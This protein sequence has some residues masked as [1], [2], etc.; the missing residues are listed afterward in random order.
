VA[1]EERPRH[2]IIES[3][4][5]ALAGLL[6]APQGPANG[7]VLVCHG[8]G[9]RKENHADFA[10]YA[11]GRGLAALIF[12]FRGHGES[13]GAGDDAMHHDVVAC[14]RRL[15]AESSAP[16][17][18]ARGS[19]MGGYLALHAAA[20]R[21]GL[22]SSVVAICPASED[23][24]LDGLDKLDDMVARGDREAEIYGR[25]DSGLM[26]TFYRRNDLLRRLRGMR[27]VLL[28]HCRD[29]D[30]VPVAHSERLLHALAEP[31]R[32][33]ALP[34]GGH[35]GAQHDP[36]VHRASLDWIVGA[37]RRRGE[38]AKGETRN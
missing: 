25:F 32:L 11:A 21:P 6:F 24:M 35:S 4:G 20:G 16:W 30:V 12:D 19:S 23:A 1:D 34:S 17:I 27:D 10:T 31:R 29:D 3:D 15:L 5:L 22:F 13:A 38:D 28:V 37:A 8:A 14:A 2:L 7:A 26:R 18:A 36:V 33:L 9:S